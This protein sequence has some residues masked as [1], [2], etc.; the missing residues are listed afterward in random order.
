MVLYSLRLA[1]ENM[2]KGKS[3]IICTIIICLILLVSVPLAV[4]LLREFVFHSYEQDKT[5]QWENGTI[6]VAHSFIPIYEE[7]EYQ[8]YRFLIRNRSAFC[9][10]YTVAERAQCLELTFPVEDF[11]IEKDKVF[12]E[13]IFFDEAVPH[14]EKWYL[15]VPAG[16]LGEYQFKIVKT[17]ERFMRINMFAWNDK[18]YTLRFLSA[19]MGSLD[20]FT[21]END[22]KKFIQN[23]FHIVW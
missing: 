22:F 13:L 9:D 20:Y 14:N 16:Q 21:D 7:K 2:K 15:P 19:S 11:S 8:G 10:F 3:L 4:P 17:D 6:E 5:K 1:G 18:T 23:S 12:S